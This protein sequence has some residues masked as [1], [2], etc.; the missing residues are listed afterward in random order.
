MSDLY[1][2]FTHF[3]SNRDVMYLLYIKSLLQQRQVVMPYVSVKMHYTSVKM[4]QD[5]AQ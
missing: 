3:N 5:I 1:K 2:C 4:H